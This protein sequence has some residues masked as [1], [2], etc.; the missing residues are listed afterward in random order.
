MVFDVN[1]QN[2]ELHLNTVKVSIATSGTGS[3]GAAYLYQGSTL[4]TSAS[5]SGGLAT[6]NN[7]PRGTAGTVIAKDQT[8]PYTV[9]VDV[10]GVTSGTLS[11]TAA[12]A[13][14]SFSAMTVYNSIDGTVTVNG[15]ASGAAQTVAASGPLFSLASAPTI[16]KTSTSDSSGNVTAVYSA[17]FNVNVTAVGTDVDFGLPASTT[18][19]FGTTTTG[20]NL[21][22]I[23][24]N[25]AAT[26]TGAV[27]AAYSKPTIATLSADGSYFTLA[28]N[29]TATIPVTYTFTILNPLAGSFAVQLQGV[30]WEKGSA[31]SALTQTTFMSG[32][33]EWR[34]NSI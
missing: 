33:P 4:V 6:F 10:T 5:V 13:T 31:G 29:Q 11:V 2:D 3:V 17:T 9:K 19:S 23:Y 16:T 22:Q 26:S 8:L 7:I 25:G 20:Y 27:T 28:R 34:T 24:K 21:A 30:Q 1:A 32:A 14:S 12:V 15:S 18:A